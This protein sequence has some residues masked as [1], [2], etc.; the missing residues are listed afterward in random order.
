MVPS[1]MK[2]V[3]REGMVVRSLVFPV[4]LTAGAMLATVAVVTVTRSPPIVVIDSAMDLPDLVRDVEVQGWQVQR[5]PN[6]REAVESG[7][8]WAGLDEDGLWI[9]GFRRE[10][11]A[12]EGLIRTHRGALWRPGTEMTIV[13]PDA[14]S[15]ESARDLVVFLGA[16][17]AFYG[18]IFGAGMVARDRD[19][20]ILEVEHTLGV[21]T[22]THGAARWLAGSLTSGGFMVFVI[23]L[24][25]SFLG[26]AQPTNM[27]LHGVAAT[28]AATAIGMIVIG[29]SGI[30]R[31]FAASLSAGLVVVGSLLSL[32]VSDGPGSTWLPIASLTSREAAGAP[33]LMA[34]VFGAVAV[35]LFSR[36]SVV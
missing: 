22:W 19:Q 36:R 15:G 20:G 3:L 17:Y 32:G 5:S 11:L 16:L 4:M 28:T 30:E 12:L 6:P 8:V 23:A 33:L 34:L 35:S 31:G 18:L 1:L 27:A 13:R 21:A 25:H 14:P 29:R 2:R 9:Y 24:F 10:T 26:L 7:Q